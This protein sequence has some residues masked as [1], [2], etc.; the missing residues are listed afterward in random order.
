MPSVV[1][2]GIGLK[3]DENEKNE[4]AAGSSISNQLPV[5]PAANLWITVAPE[6]NWPAGPSWQD[7]PVLSLYTPM[8]SASAV[9]ELTKQQPISTTSALTIKR[10]TAPCRRFHRRAV[11]RAITRLAYIEGT[12]RRQ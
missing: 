3:G 6:L 10:L 12:T 4:V 2:F 1:T 9:L 11:L 8:W 5:A 7:E